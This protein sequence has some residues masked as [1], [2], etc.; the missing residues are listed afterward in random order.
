MGR[1]WSTNGER[2][3]DKIVKGSEMGLEG[4]EADGVV[5]GPCAMDY[6]CK[7]GVEVGEVRGRD[8]KGAVGHVVGQGNNFRRCASREDE[9]VVA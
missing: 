9:I 3:V 4:R 2:E 1:L 6:V 8:A 5:C 7:G